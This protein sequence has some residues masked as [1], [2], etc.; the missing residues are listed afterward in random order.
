MSRLSDRQDAYGHAMLDFH[1]RKGGYEMTASKREIK[2]FLLD[3][4]ILEFHY[5]TQFFKAVRFFVAFA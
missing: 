2:D 5:G 4:R 3:N 1:L